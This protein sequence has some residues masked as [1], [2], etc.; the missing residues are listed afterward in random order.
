[1]LDE[2]S[3]WDLFLDCLEAGHWIGRI[4]TIGGIVALA[5][6]IFAAGLFLRPATPSPMA[7]LVIGTPAAMTL[8]GVVISDP[9]ALSEVV[10]DLNHLHP[11]PDTGIRI[12]SC[13]SSNGDRYVVRFTYANG[14]RWTVTVDR[15]G[16]QNVT[17]G[18]F[19]PRTS[20]SS[21]PKLLADLDAI[22]SR[23]FR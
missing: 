20:V 5:A 12:S 9:A 6:V 14:D 4:L 13:P 3:R 23:A 22:F 16:C 17:A 21:N 19:W 11:Y 7:T 2:V 8:N 1:M 18:G 10:A 15:Y